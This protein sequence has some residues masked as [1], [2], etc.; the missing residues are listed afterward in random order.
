MAH[1]HHI[2]LAVGGVSLRDRVEAAAVKPAVAHAHKGKPVIQRLA[3]NLH[4]IMLRD[5]LDHIDHRGGG[6]C[7]EA[8]QIGKPLVVGNT[9][10]DP[11]IQTHRAD[12]HC[13]GVVAADH[14]KGGFLCV[15]QPFQVK[16]GLGVAE[17]PHKIIAAAKGEHRHRR[18]GESGRAG[19]HLVEG[20]VS[21]AG[22]DPIF[23][24]GFGGLAGQLPA[25]SG[26][27]G[28]LNAEIQPP[29]I[30]GLADH[31]GIFPGAV[32]AA[33]RR[34]DDKQMLHKSSVKC[35]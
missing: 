21:A 24:A 2:Q 33:R 28:N 25:V 14:I 18:I 10:A 31:G 27:S 9:G 1:Q 13:Q 3:V 35:F 17:H 7:P 4:H 30:T 23:F 6:V 15:Q 16:K 26:V 34:V 32:P 29:D 12:I 20:A 11:G 5:P 8:L 19:G 22:V